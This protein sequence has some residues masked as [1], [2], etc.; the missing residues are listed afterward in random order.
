MPVVIQKQGI[1]CSFTA[2]SELTWRSALTPLTSPFQTPEWLTFVLS[3]LPGARN[4]SR[5]YTFKDGTSAC[6]PM[7]SIPGALGRRHCWSMPDD[8]Y[9]GPIG[10]LSSAHVA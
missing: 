4:A 1:E 2:L 3:S 6:V 7:V 5:L 8:E 10:E 9:G